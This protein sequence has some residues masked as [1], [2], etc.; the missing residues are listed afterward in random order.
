MGARCC[1]CGVE[2]KA[3]GAL[4]IYRDRSTNRITRYCPE[5]WERIR[6]R[7]FRLFFLGLATDA[8]AGC[9]LV[10]YDPENGFGWIL[11]NFLLLY[12]FLIVAA[13]PH[14][15][16]HAFV[17]RA[18]GFRV[19][20]VVIGSGRTVLER[21]L[22]GSR[23]QVNSIPLGGHVL[24]LP[25]DAK[26]YRAKTILLTLA[27]PLA[28]LLVV[29]VL[30]A[31]VRDWSLELD[32]A[33]GPRPLSVCCIANL[34]IFAWIFFPRVVNIDGRETPN[35][36]LIIWRTLR[37]KDPQIREV[38]TYWFYYEALQ[39]LE[40]TDYPS[41]N[42]WFEKGL[43]AFPGNV[44]LLQGQASGL[45][46]LRRFN[47]AREIYLG[48]VGRSGLEQYYRAYFANGL[49]YADALLGGEERL[50]EAD[51]YSREALEAI[52]FLPHFKGTRGAV[53]VELG[54]FDEGILL[55]KEALAK[56]QDAASKALNAAHIAIAEQRRGNTAEA[57][58]FAALARSLDSNC[59][60]LDR[61]PGS[62]AGSIPDQTMGPR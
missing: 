34:I 44:Y 55:L 40:A 32:F 13:V 62:P 51:Q 12:A 9:L 19:F 20:K 16:G 7:R 29:G 1:I 25:R 22:F 17:A 21:T 47:E 39:C 38:P 15:L 50:R 43:A 48:L 49:A 36:A 46:H 35:D 31:M 53:L 61:L 37:M 59:I 4:R 23:F 33:Q 28:N 24:C 30:L 14:E 56:N 2:C 3:D 41:A 42:D 52:S 45:I 27:G 57:E 10:L 6:D 26:G 8:V 58:K 60:L 5:C 11:L 18:V 54:Q